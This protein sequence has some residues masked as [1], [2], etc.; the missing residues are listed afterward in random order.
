MYLN[1]LQTLIFG[2]ILSFLICFVA[3]E[4]SQDLINT[5]Q[6]EQEFTMEEGKIVTVKNGEDYIQLQL[7]NIEDSRCPANAN[8]VRAGEAV[9][10]VKI[11]DSK[12]RESSFT[13]YFGEKSNFKPDT[14]EFSV[15]QKNYAIIL[16]NVLPYPDLE[17][18]EIKTAIFEVRKF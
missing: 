13:M 8:C 16:N 14:T 4:Q 1:N 9:V 18:K 2:S 5:Y 10:N 12:N 7:E 17:Q 15:Q 11:T 3:C 6:T